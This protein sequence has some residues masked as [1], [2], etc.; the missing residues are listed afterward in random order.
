M[1]ATLDPALIDAAKTTPHVCWWPD[2]DDEV[3]QLGVRES[4]YRSDVTT[5]DG[6]FADARFT[7]R[8]HAYLLWSHGHDLHPWPAIAGQLEEWIARIRNARVV[9]AVLLELVGEGR[10]PHL[11]H[12][13]AKHAGHCGLCGGNIAPKRSRVGRL[14]VAFHPI[15]GLL[16]DAHRGRWVDERT[17]KPRPADATRR[18]HGRCIERHLARDWSPE[19][20]KEIAEERIATLRERNVAAIE[21]Y[22]KRRAR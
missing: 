11:R 14:P 7:C 8:R 6:S 12:G 21:R 10:H 15:K 3:T 22:E 20:Q 17:A 4:T 1:S 16:F 19:R 18:A 13:P 9:D 5:R 2:C